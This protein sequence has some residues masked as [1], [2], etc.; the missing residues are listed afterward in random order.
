ML[1][2]KFPKIT[3]LW[4][5]ILFV[6]HAFSQDIATPSLSKDKKAKGSFYFAWGY[7]KDW[8]SRS[9]IHFHGSSSDN[10]EFT[11]HDVTSKDA[12]NFNKIFAVDISI[13]QYIYRFGYYLGKNKNLGIEISFDHAK[14]IMIQNQTAH[15]TGQIH[16]V[17]IDKDTVLTDEF[18]KFEHTNGANFLML[19]ALKRVSLLHSKQ[20]THRLQGVVKPGAGIVIP[21]SDV[22]LFN[23]RQNNVFHIAGYIVGAEASLRYE[24]GKHLFAETGFKGTFANYTHVLTV[25]DAQASHHFFCLEWLLS[26]GYQ[27]AL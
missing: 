6:S 24:A 11:L 17:A 26:I 20:G 5:G 7:N 16:G 2:M 4:A 1:L 9:D 22:R 18:V 10:Y 8:F 23:V 15:V 25:G 13:P 21:R 3:L 19:T 12:P 27:I 14:Y